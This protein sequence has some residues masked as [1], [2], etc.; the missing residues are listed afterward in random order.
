M[1][2]DFEKEKS[3]N[4]DSKETKEK[5]FTNELKGL[6]SIATCNHELRNKYGNSFNLFLSSGYSLVVY[7]PPELI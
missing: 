4:E 2:L 5:L 7:S 6:K 1:D 3:D